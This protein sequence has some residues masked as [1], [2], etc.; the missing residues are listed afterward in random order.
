M[1]GPASPGAA[2]RRQASSSF[3]TRSIWSTLFMTAGYSSSSGDRKVPKGQSE[4]NYFRGVPGCAKWSMSKNTVKVAS[5][6]T[7]VIAGF[8]RTC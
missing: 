6:N 1:T 7:T 8:L 2:L 5:I 4:G 3:I